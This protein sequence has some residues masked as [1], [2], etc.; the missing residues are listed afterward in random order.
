VLEIRRQNLHKKIY[1]KQGKTGK[2]QIKHWTTCL[3]RAV[4]LALAQQKGIKSVIWVFANR[5]GCICSSTLDNRFIKAKKKSQV[6][7]LNMKFNCTFYDAKTKA[8]YS[9]ES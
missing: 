2:E 9:F 7:S 1:I 5:S 4:D 6:T 3:R 8:I